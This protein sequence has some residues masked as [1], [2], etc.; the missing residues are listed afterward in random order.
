MPLFLPSVMRRSII[1]AVLTALA[2]LLAG[3]SAVRLTYNQGPQL[4]YWRLDSYIDFDDAQKPL[5]KQAIAEWFQWNR[6]TQLKDYAA[7]LAR[8]AQQAAEP[9]TAAAACRWVE[10]ITARLQT[11]YERALPSAADF[12]LTLTPAQVS[13]LERK[14]AKG[15]DEFADEHLQRSP[16]DRLAAAVKRLVKDADRLYGSVTPAQRE[17]IER[18]LV[19]SPY[20][21]EVVLAE[22]KARQLE[23]LSLARRWVADRSPAAKIQADLHLLG[24][25]AMHSPRDNYRDYQQRVRPFNCTLSAQ[26]H[27]AATPAQRQRAVERLRG[28]EADLQ[29][30]M[31]QA[32]P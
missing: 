12:L 4:A 5:A 27:N 11:A 1:G 29:A 28:W 23:T 13:H 3:C 7:L 32:A 18:T 17:L 14:Y 24:E 25:H 19:G 31:A 16:K 22:R 20:D 30:L 9:T 21:P 8:A 26:I 2:L 6:T 15:D 10:D